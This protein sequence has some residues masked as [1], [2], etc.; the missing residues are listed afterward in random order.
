MNGRRAWRENWPDLA[1]GG[2]LAVTLAVN[3]LVLAEKPADL[4]DYL[5][6]AAGAGVL[7][8]G[9]RVPAVALV[10]STAAMVAYSLRSDPGV[11]A[12]VPVLVAIFLA[13]RAGTFVLSSV[14]GL[15]FL[16]ASFA[17]E[18]LGVADGRPAR[19]ITERLGLAMG[20]FVAAIVAGVVSR[21]RQA[22][23]EQVEQ[24]AV[25]AERTREEAA[26][27]RAGEE[28]LRIARE[29][30]DSLTHNISIIKLQAGVAVHLHRKR[31]EEVPEA[32]LAI[33]EASTEAMREL[34]ATLDVLRR[35]E[36]E[37]PPNGL[38]RLGELAERFRSA[39]LA[40]TLSVRGPRRPLP[41]PVEQAAYRIVQ[42]SLTN[43]TRHAGGAPATVL[44]TYEADR[45]VVQV[46]DAGTAEPDP[47]AVP[48]V[49][50]IGMR[51]RVTALGGR[52]TAGPRPGGGFRVRAELPAPAA[53]APAADAPP[54]EEALPAVDAPPA[55]DSAV[56]VRPG[57]A[58]T[59]EER[60]GAVPVHA[61]PEGTAA[62]D[63][64]Q[65][66]AA[67]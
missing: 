3:S 1:L 24:R 42:E 51:E 2:G 55:G 54:A 46:D 7:V 53:D 14:A 62:G 58:A 21:H 17:V 18:L 36:D 50:L 41:E 35:P 29:L 39:G 61:A 40:T 63:R 48:G 16:S 12:M 57:A 38:H 30:H 60:A 6:M 23:L 8:V 20:W 64:E 47:S 34:R 27:R 65:G 49:G 31:G 9:R 56:A 37:A 10:V 33:Q 25:E 52:L 59:G 11:S 15:L 28:R 5:L 32:L 13:V 67:R 26:L 19:Q 44:L 22:Y 45:L 43:V 66:G 4:L